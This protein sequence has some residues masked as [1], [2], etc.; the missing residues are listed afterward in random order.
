M[1]E[2][3]NPAVRKEWYGLRTIAG[4]ITPNGIVNP[5]SVGVH[6]A[7]RLN[8]EGLSVNRRSRRAVGAD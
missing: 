5:F 7:Q 6:L 2:K 1:A 3:I 8:A 4:R